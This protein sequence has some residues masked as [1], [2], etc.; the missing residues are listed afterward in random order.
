[1]GQ[2]Q[3]PF[4]PEG[5]TLISR[6]LSFEKRNNSVT[7]FY[8][9][10]PIFTHDEDDTTTF[11][12][13][14]SQFYVNGYVKQMDIV[15]AF[16]VTKISVKRSVALYR[17]KGTRGFYEPRKTRGAAVLTEPVLIQVQQLLDE[18]LDVKEIA[19]QLQLK[20]DTLAK[21]IKSGKLHKPIKKK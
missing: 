13:I 3:L 5:S 11:R 21:A 10:L 2:C 1:M 15:R 18:G 7:Y 14:T 4:F 20:R 12:M 17:A 16:G 8:G 9:S 6:E 19:E